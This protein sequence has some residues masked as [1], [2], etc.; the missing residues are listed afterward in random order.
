[1]VRIWIEYQKEGAGGT[2]R[3]SKNIQSPWR[4]MGSPSRGFSGAELSAENIKENSR[5][6]QNPACTVVLTPVGTETGPVL[7]G[8]QIGLTNHG[9]RVDN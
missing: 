8:S 5:M 9:Y 4:S 2:G 1:M 6:Q 7:P 3:E